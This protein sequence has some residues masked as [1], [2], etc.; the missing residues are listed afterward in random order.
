MTCALPPGSFAGIWPLVYFTFLARLAWMAVNRPALPHYGRIGAQ[1]RPE[2]SRV[3]EPL[4]GEGGG[5]HTAI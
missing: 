4:S 3:A 1:E 2:A 5:R